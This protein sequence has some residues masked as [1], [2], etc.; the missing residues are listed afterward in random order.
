MKEKLKIL[1]VDDDRS[2]GKLIASLLDMEGYSYQVVNR[3]EEAID[4]LRSESFDVVIS[5]IYMGEVSGLDVL[6]AARESQ[7]DVEVIIM[8]AHGS[9]ETAV[10]AVRKGAFDY[11]SKPFAVEDVLGLIR[12]IEEKGRLLAKGTLGSEV[13]D[14]LPNTEIVG[15]SKVMVGI[16]TK[17]A[18]VAAIDSPALIYGETGAGKEGETGA[19]KELVARAVH[20]NSAR[21]SAPFVVINCGALTETLLESELFGHEKGAFTGAVASRK[22][23]FEGAAGGTVFLDE[24]SETSLSFQVKL[25][26]VIQEH[27]I[28]RVGSNDTVAVDIRTVAATNRDLRELVRKEQFREDLFHRLNVFTISIP[29]LRERQGD[30]PVLASYFLKTYGE[31]YEREVRLL[32]EALIILERHN[33]PGNVRELKNVME[34][35][36]AFCENDVISP[37]DLELVGPEVNETKEDILPSGSLEDMERDH[38]IRTL[39]ETGGNKKKAA[40][41]LG[42]ER[43]T[44]Y[45][46]AERLGI[47]L[48]RS[49]A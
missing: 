21:S 17:I 19:G 10:Q 20:Q 12:R 16:Y 22:G 23:L 29:P 30:I 33:W 42:I 24:I 8:T 38:I 25:L 9:V 6:E 26:R 48:K 44:L 31:E 13:A 37:G 49:Q 34:R 35:A 7:T 46:K 11:I 27:E 15:T 40:E 5:D 36:F 4:L 43:R 45:N 14:E 41:I 1:V 18:R 3:G 28:R 2:I 32:P 47:D 39:K